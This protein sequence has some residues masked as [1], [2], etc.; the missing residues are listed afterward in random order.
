MKK[1]TYILC[2]CLLCIVAFIEIRHNIPG[3]G[4]EEKDRK[5]VV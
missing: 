1:T 4:P 2:V 5:S 3:N